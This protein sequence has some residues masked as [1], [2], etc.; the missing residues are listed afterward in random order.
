MRRDEEGSPLI[1]KDLLVAANFEKLN[2]EPFRE[3]IEIYRLYAA[4]GGAS[5]AVLRYAPGAMLPR[6][7]HVG[8]EQI[9]VLRGSQI[10]DAGEHHAGTCVVYPPGSSHAVRSAAGCVVLVTWERPVR[11]LPES[12]ESK[13]E[14][15]S[16]GR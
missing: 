10:D 8:F 14:L 12:S 7:V 11:F 3:G 15:T 1:L 4:P 9:M 5:A 6:H 16:R 13:P 2:W